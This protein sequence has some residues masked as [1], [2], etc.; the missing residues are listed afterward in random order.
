MPV[1]NF[2]KNGTIMTEK[3]SHHSSTLIS[4]DKNRKEKVATL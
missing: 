3:L 4:K 2:D 1:S